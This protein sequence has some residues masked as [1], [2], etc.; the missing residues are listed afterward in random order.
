MVG[1]VLGL[2]SVVVVIVLVVFFLRYSNVAVKASKSGHPN[3]ASQI[4][5]YV[6][7]P[8]IVVAIILMSFAF[9]TVKTVSPTEVAV[10]TRF[11]SI[12]GIKTSGLYTS[13]L[14]ETYNKYDKR[15]QEI[16]YDGSANEHS[17]ITFY[18]KDSQTVESMLTLQWRI[19]PEDAIKIYSNF[20]TLSLLSEKLSSLTI[21]RTK[22]SLSSFNAEGLIVSRDSLSG[23]IQS[24]INLTVLSNDVPVEITATYLTDF[25]FSDAFEAAV[26]AKMI[27]EQEKLKAETEKEIAIIKAEQELEIAKI[28]AEKAIV[29]AQAAAQASA[30]TASGEASKLRQMVVEVARA[31]GFEV[32][33]EYLKDSLGEDTLVISEYVIVT[34]GHTPEEVRL[35]MDYVEFLLWLEAWD[36]K[37]PTTLVTDDGSIVIPIPPQP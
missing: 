32:N 13:K 28:E 4:K 33:I 7:G 8:A 25:S 34:A 24:A 6:F 21:E 18:S 3:K 2:I 17:I 20:G 22:S 12:N 14:F 36:G 26:E 15:I 37:L 10:V 29:Q 27:A 9:S 16:R 23:L 35:I 19:K 31:L 1:I 30:I 11:G 5:T